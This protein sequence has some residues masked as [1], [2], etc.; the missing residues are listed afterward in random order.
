MKKFFTKDQLRKLHES[1]SALKKCGKRA[2]VCAFA[3]TALIGCHAVN[4]YADE[5]Y[6]VNATESKSTGENEASAELA[7]TTYVSGDYEYSLEDGQ[8]IITKY[9]GTDANVIIPSSVMGYEV[10]GIGRNAFYNNKT[11]QSV[12]VPDGVSI[13]GSSVFQGCTVLKNISL[14]DGLETIG[15]SAFSGCKKLKSVNVPKSISK[16]ESNA[17]YGCSGMSNVVFNENSKTGFKQTI[18]DWAFYGCSGLE[19][20]N[21]TLN[22][23][24]IGDRAFSGCSGLEAVHLPDNIKKIGKC[25]FE[26]CSALTELVLPSKL[27]T[28]GYS[29]I[30]G[31]EITEI[32]IPKT[33]KNCD[34]NGNYSYG[35]FIGADSIKTIKIEEGMETI[36]S[37]LCQGSSIENVEIPESV[38]NIGGSAFAGC[39]MLKSVSLPDG[40]ETIGSSAFLGCKKLKSVNVPKS[41]S[42]IE[43]NAFNGCSGL[44]NVVFNENSKTGFKQ[45]IGYCAFYGCSGLETLN[46]TSNVTEMGEK[47]FSGCSGLE[48]VHL[49]DNVKK[50]GMYAF[51][52]CSALTEL[53]L[54]SKLE[55]IGYSIISG[56]EITE[57]TIPKTVKNCAPNGYYSC[58]P[59]IG[60]DS[61]KT[62][63]IEEGMETIPSSLCKGSSIENIEIPESVKT[64]ESSAFYGCSKLQKI[65]IYPWVTEGKI[66]KDVFSGCSAL[67]I[68]GV[69]GSYAQTYASDNNIKFKSFV[70][71][72]YTE[73]GT[74]TKVD[75]GN[76]IIGIDDKEYEVS[77]SFDLTFATKILVDYPNKNII[78][79]IHNGEAGRFW[80]VNDIMQM[81]ASITNR[82]TGGGSSKL[83]Y[84]DGSMSSDSID[85]QVKLSYEMTGDCPYTT[86]D[87]EGLTS[88]KVDVESLRIKLNGDGMTLEPHSASNDKQLLKGSKN[89]PIEIVPGEPVT[90]NFSVNIDS[91]YYPSAVNTT[92]SITAE[93]KYAGKDTYITPM[94]GNS[95]YA[96]HINNRDQEKAEREARKNQQESAKAVNSAVAKVKRDMISLVSFEMND[97]LSGQ[98][99]KDMQD[100]LS[101]WIA[102]AMVSGKLSYS[103]QS[104]ALRDK[105]FDKLG[106]NRKSTLFGTTTTMTTKIRANTAKGRKIFRFTVKLNGY[107]LGTGNAFSSFGNLTYDVLDENGNKVEYSGVGGTVSANI[108]TFTDSVEELLDSEGKAAFDLGYGNDLNKVAEM[109]IDDSILKVIN[110]KCGSVS[111]GMFD[112][113]TAPA[114]Q[115]RKEATVS[116]TGKGRVSSVGYIDT[117]SA[118]AI[119]D[120]NVIGADGSIL[121]IYKDGAVDEQYNTIFMY[122]D[123]DAVHISFGE[124]NCAIQFVNGNAEDV[125]VVIEEKSDDVTTRT[126]MYSAISIASGAKIVIPENNGTQLYAVLDS[127]GETVD[128]DEDT[129]F[130]NI[131]TDV[132]VKGISYSE[133][134]KQIKV[135]ETCSVVPTFKPLNATN[136]SV[137]YTVSNSKLATVTDAGTIKGLAA[138]TVKVTA[139]SVDGAYTAECTVVIKQAEKK[140]TAI[141]L[142]GISQKIAV[143]KQI[144]IT[145][146]VA[147]ANATNKGITWTSSNSKYAVVSASG[148][149]TTKSAG[150]GKTVTITAKAKDGSGVKASYKITL[151]KGAVKSIKLTANSNTISAG[152]K[153]AIKPS[154]SVTNNS[155]NKT[156]IWKS[157]NTK[158]ATVSG[159]GIVTMNKA[160]IG[161]IV[162]ITA[163]STD[164]SGIKASYKVKIVKGAVQSIKLTAK[165]S[166]VQAGKQLTI[167]AT[168]K[169][170]DNT[171]NKKL[172]WVSSNSKY[173]SVSAKGVVVGKKAGKGKVVTITAKALDGTGKKASI[174]IKVK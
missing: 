41:V 17:F 36:P 147:P 43:S 37:S 174:K 79:E 88:L 22:V 25:A 48:I 80:A 143:G 144:K 141:K 104:S 75:A 150:A 27:E 132:K 45:T 170:T 130:D 33:V 11:L 155:A 112:L 13:I 61:L 18:G 138:G 172:L 142:T 64:I 52:N 128:P 60:A 131:E 101:M 19:T 158:Y 118:D 21:L 47:A 44:S 53:V 133:I 70:L 67:T 165:S 120:F 31:T 106:V 168:V 35:S 114:K 84:T 173:A 160:G 137:I 28:I 12:V 58:G 102:Q 29:I 116:R 124:E 164:G 62:I 136:T 77:N 30:S 111:N 154:V 87:L 49:P 1:N 99:M 93:L 74:L 38:R 51:E 5:A 98:Q 32:T 9:T 156:M 6:S 39:I 100:I 26:N 23:T 4:V 57:I 14:P 8:A 54:P 140:V 69:E 71:E 148:V 20:I 83:Y 108:T 59:F 81:K 96:I 66:E 113:L 157:S 123:G 117:E 89:S 149:V 90:Y 145:A 82:S 15:S 109:I 103:T 76:G 161:K 85:F 7:G 159:T 55:T 73:V 167:K 135:G 152:K 110:K 166:T 94:I 92:S 46:L 10:V 122:E 151:M 72:N 40:L 24:E 2:I 95:I 107:G 162:T 16:I 86:H 125:A 129:L 134:T 56:T 65:T 163:S 127:A 68:Y 121:A 3:A 126:I 146:T 34:S 63:K 171:A 153:L 169:A 115:F 139:E 50:I 42:K 105:L 119:P 97:Y 78:C 91:G